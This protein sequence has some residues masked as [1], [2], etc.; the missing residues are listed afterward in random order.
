MQFYDSYKQII[1]MDCR[2]ILL[3]VVDISGDMSNSGD[4]YF[5]I[6]KIKENS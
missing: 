1:S 4:I 2:C 5:E 6:N 3:S